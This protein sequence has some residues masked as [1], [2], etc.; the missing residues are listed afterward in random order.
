[1]SLAPRTVTPSEVFDGPVALENTPE[2]QNQDSAKD[3]ANLGL[4]G[5]SM[6]SCSKPAGDY[7]EI[8]QS[9]GIAL[10]SGEGSSSSTERETE[11][12]LGPYEWLDNEIKRL[13]SIL[14]S[15]QRVDPSGNHGLS[16][17][18]YGENEV[19]WVIKTDQDMVNGVVQKDAKNDGQELESY[20]IWGS[21]GDDHHDEMTTAGDLQVFNSSSPGNSGFDR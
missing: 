7:A 21:N 12:V 16:S 14:Q 2:V 15:D 4:H 13:R 11:E 10:S 18:T 19:G 17:T 3:L 9:T 5:S 8:S 20:G 6:N 1:M